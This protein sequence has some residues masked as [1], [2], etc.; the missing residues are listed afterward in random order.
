ML[1]EKHALVDEFPHFK[2]LIAQLKE[3]NKQFSEMAFR[4]DE[5]DSEIRKLELDNAPIGDD[6]MHKLK[7][8]RAQLKDKLYQHLLKHQ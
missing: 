4:Y 2:Q 8:D 6:A 7:Q 3:K 5:L 1:G